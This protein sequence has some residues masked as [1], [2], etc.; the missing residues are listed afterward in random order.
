M[1]LKSFAQH[2]DHNK[3]PAASTFEVRGYFI[4]R[5]LREG[6]QGVVLEAVRDS[7][8]RSVAIKVLAGG[9]PAGDRRRRRFEREMAIMENIRHE[10]IVHFIEATFTTSGDPCYIMDWVDGPAIG[11]FWSE[12]GGIGS[13]E[14]F[15][16][17]VEQAGKII[18]AVSFA[19]AQGVVHRDLKP[20]NILIESS[21]VPRILDFGLAHTLAGQAAGKPSVIT[22]SGE[23]AGSYYY[24]APE[25]YEGD[26]SL[27]DVRSDIYSLGAIFYETLAGVSPFGD[28]DSLAALID[29]ILHDAP[30]PPST[31]RAQRP[32]AADPG[33]AKEM[34]WLDIVVLKMIS[35]RREDRYQNIGDVAGELQRIASGLPPNARPSVATGKYRRRRARLALAVLSITAAVPAIWWGGLKPIFIDVAATRSGDEVAIATG[36]EAARTNRVAEAE[37]LIWPVFLNSPGVGAE[38]GAAQW[39]L[40]EIYAKN[41]CV[42]TMEGSPAPRAM[43]FSPAGDLVAHSGSSNGVELFHARTGRRLKSFE[44]GGFMSLQFSEDG[45]VLFGGGDNGNLYILPVY[46]KAEPTIIK[47]SDRPIFSIV[48]VPGRPRSLYIC[49]WRGSIVRLNLAEPAAPEIIVNLDSDATQMVLDS[50]KTALIAGA[51]TM[52]LVEVSLLNENKDSPVRILHPRWRQASIVRILA[53]PHAP[54]VLTQHGAASGSAYLYNYDIKKEGEPLRLRG[55]EQISWDGTFKNVAYTGEDPPVVHLVPKASFTDGSFEAKR[56]TISGLRSPSTRMSPGPGATVIVGESSGAIRVFPMETNSWREAVSPVARSASESIHAIDL[57]EKAGV[58]VSSG[59]TDGRMSLFDIHDNRELL[60]FE[61][62]RR[63]VLSLALDPRNRRKLA[64]VAQNDPFVRIWDLSGPEAIQVKN[65]EIVGGA[66]NVVAFSPDGGLLLVGGMSGDVTVLGDTYEIQRKIQFH[67]GRISSICFSR[68]GKRVAAS[69]AHTDCRV[70]IFNISDLD[71][72]SLVLRHPLVVHCV[73]WSMDGAVIAT[74]TGDTDRK[75]RIWSGSDGSLV[76]TIESTVGRIYSI[77][78]HP[79]GR[80]LAVGGASGDVAVY[81]ARTWRLL[82][83]FHI[84]DGGVFNIKYSEDGRYIYSCGGDN[85]VRRSDFELCDKYIAGNL[86]YQERLHGTS[87]KV[88]PSLQQLRQWARGFLEK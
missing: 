49:D 12:K 32:G 83:Q 47:I 25:Q 43:A 72:P 3:K 74:G 81:D 31:R 34:E 69:A 13:R 55:F 5:V 84:H 64:A 77:R 53:N 46:S 75:L 1:K 85:V 33:I 78:F 27:I 52:G 51:T 14:A 59:A 63:N 42:L 67:W 38:T 29:G 6:G 37:D 10:N 23:F 73:D 21:G 20:S 9:L 2:L 71:H 35:K 15:S 48:V 66:G 61:E 4:I 11:E 87:K 70:S 56:K 79:G 39:A 60:Q 22:R 41:P 17:W 58:L 44:G 36:R 86:D 24:A 76:K 88:S 65:V 8:G 54:E 50:S 18:D 80:L 68:D 45:T 7:D 26:P 16:T 19:H 28:R 62:K 82:A 57:D 40:R 30:V